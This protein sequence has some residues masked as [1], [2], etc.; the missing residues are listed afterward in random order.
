MDTR[1]T[2]DSLA[3]L[4]VPQGE[5]HHSSKTFTSEKLRLNLV[6]VMASLSLW[7]SVFSVSNNPDAMTP[8]FKPFYFAE[9]SAHYRFRRAAQA[10][11]PDFQPVLLFR[12][13][14]S[15]P[16]QVSYHGASILQV[17]C[18]LASCPRKEHGFS[19]S[20]SRIL[21]WHFPV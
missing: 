2:T 3:E 19:T 21:L 5:Q 16:R 17:P 11:S 14:A 4:H 15:L 8:S 18:G 6:L 10:S 7:T 12:T 13:R 9:L 20:L 1:I